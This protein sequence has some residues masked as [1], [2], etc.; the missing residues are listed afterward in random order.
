MMLKV[1]QVRHVRDYVVFLRFNNGV[2]GEV[3]LAGE[4]T[5]PVF[6]P[7]RDLRLFR[8]VALDPETWT[9]AWPNGADMAA[10]FLLSLLSTDVRQ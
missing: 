5:G 2:E 3:D 8:Q 4:L 7:L 9:V 1:D 10:E 6:E